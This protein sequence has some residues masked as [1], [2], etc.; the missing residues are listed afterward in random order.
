MKIIIRL[1]SNAIA[2]YCL[3][4]KKKIADDR[5]GSLQCAQDLGMAQWSSSG[6]L[7]A[8][9]T[10]ATN[11]RIVAAK[12]TEQHNGLSKSNKLQCTGHSKHTLTMFS[13][14]CV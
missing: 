3:C 4:Q 9:K 6:P 8:V 13:R 2:M 7:P 1:H 12:I 5:L 14:S 10:A 11:C